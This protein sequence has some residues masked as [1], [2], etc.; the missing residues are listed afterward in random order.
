MESGGY[1][2]G[3]VE[4]VIGVDGEGGW[5]VRRCDRG[6]GFGVGDGGYAVGRGGGRH[7]CG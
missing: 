5:V 1:V 6:G 2:R 7:A 4:G 3:A